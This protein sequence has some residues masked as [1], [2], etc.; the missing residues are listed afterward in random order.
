MWLIVLIISQCLHIAKMLLLMLG[1]CSFR[2]SRPLSP[3]SD[4]QTTFR[5]CP[6]NRIELSPAWWAMPGTATTKKWDI[7]LVKTWQRRALRGG[8]ER[9]RRGHSTPWTET[10][11]QSVSRLC[12]V[13]GMTRSAM[14]S[15]RRPFFF[16]AGW[17]GE[18]A[19]SSEP[20]PE[21]ACHH[22][23]TESFRSNRGH[24]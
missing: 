9:D 11:L 18:T 23:D 24:P 3:A 14:L 15:T 2:R 19:R 16:L 1:C 22:L 6:Q 20:P 21:G 7:S 10:S 5:L 4:S 8:S 12:S 17:W 13:R